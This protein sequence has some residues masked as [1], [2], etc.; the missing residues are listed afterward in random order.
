VER[1]K[2]SEASRAVHLS[3]EMRELGERLERGEGGGGGAAATE[4]EARGADDSD[5]RFVCSLEIQP[6]LVDQVKETAFKELNYPLMEEYDFQRDD[7]L[8]DLPIELVAPHIRD[9]QAKALSKMFG[10]GRARSGVVVL[11]CGA[12]KTLTGISAV[13][14]I[15]KSTIVL[16]TSGV[17]VKQWM[18]Q[19]NQYTRID[20]RL[21]VSFTSVDKDPWPQDKAFVR[22]SRCLSRLRTRSGACSCWT[23]STSPQRTSSESRSRTYGATPSWGSRPRSCA[24]TTRPRT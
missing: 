13:C 6:M 18:F 24:R 10:N 16:C 15:H 11:P 2:E 23:R 9:Y 8:L 17:A 4:E 3:K 12:G 7:I 20:R 14:T 22:A 19:F 21:L 5:S 1:A